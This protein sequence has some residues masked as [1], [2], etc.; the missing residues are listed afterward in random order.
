MSWTFERVPP[1]RPT[2]AIAERVPTASTVRVLWDSTVGKKAV[3]ACT[4]LLMLAFLT[5][6]MYGNL[7]IFFGPE[8]FNSY[9]AWLRTIG[10]PVLHYSWYLWIQRVVL[11]AAVIL[12]I[13]SAYQLSRRDAKAR[14][15][16]YEHRKP[17]MTFA[18]RTMRYGGVIVLLFLIWHLLD[19]SALTANPLGER[20]HPYEN[21]VADFH[22]WYANVI[23]VA[24]L[25]AL[26]LHVRH[27]FWSAAQTLGAN[28]PRSA[29]LFKAGSWIL[30]IVLTAGFL[31]V[32]IGVWTGVVS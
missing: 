8:T 12:H 5:V 21:I 19:L 14:P 29:P 20:G 22:T 28:G 27:G 26:G 11:V 1:Y 25:L 17:E 18:T 10:E 32:P 23:Y 13:V 30:A 9:A 7:K 3:M 15:V 31:A 24:G 16:K 2:V 6:H 4:G